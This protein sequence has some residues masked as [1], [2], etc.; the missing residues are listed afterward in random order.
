MTRERKQLLL[1]IDPALH[2]ALARWAADDLHSLNAQIEMI[3]RQ[4]VVKA[5]RAPANL[6]LP[7]P[8]GRPKKEQPGEPAG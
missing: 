3:L 1:R 5:G 8:R 7:P 6:P 4:A 2:D